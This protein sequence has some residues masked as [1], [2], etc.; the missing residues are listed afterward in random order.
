MKN[1][2][3]YRILFTILLVPIILLIGYYLMLFLFTHDMSHVNYSHEEM[4]ENFHEHEDDFRYLIDYF[5]DVLQDSSVEQYQIKFRR[6]ENKHHV[7]LTLLPSMYKVTDGEIVHIGGAEI[8]K[9]SPELQ[10]ALNVLGWSINTVD[11]LDVLLSKINCDVIQTVPYL[12][13]NIEIFPEQEGNIFQSYCVL[14]DDLP[15][16]LQQNI[17][18][19]IN[20]SDAGKRIILVSTH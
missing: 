16:S 20:K 10:E 14:R 5:Q 8:N 19:I 3:S 9:R 7:G 11:S 15:D 2:K 13:Y 6:S 1:S 18:K 4:V 12:R 17:G